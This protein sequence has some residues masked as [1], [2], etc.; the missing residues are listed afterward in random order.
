M[1]GS[2]RADLSSLR[3]APGFFFLYLRSDLSLGQKVCYELNGSLTNPQLSEWVQ[4]SRR[5]HHY[6]TDTPDSRLYRR[7][8]R[9]STAASYR[10]SPSLSDLFITT[11]NRRAGVTKNIKKEKQN[12]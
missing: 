5:T 3:L 8:R 2:P 1:H 12:K 9:Y 7:R 4:T 11:S 6:W 10:W